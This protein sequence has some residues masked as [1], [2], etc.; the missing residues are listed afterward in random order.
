MANINT[1]QSFPSVSLTITKKDGS[2]ATVDGVPI[3]ASSDDT[4]LRPEPVSD[5]MT[6]SVK[7]VAAGVARVVV[8]ADADLGSGVVTITGVSEDITVTTGPLS[9]AT[10]IAITLGD[11]VD[12]APA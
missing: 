2:P 8:T 10:T 11:P 9:M 4:V 1:D 7:P 12:N 6:G 5:G 3:W